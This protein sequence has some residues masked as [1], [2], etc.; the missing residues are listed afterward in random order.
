M[1]LRPARVWLKQPEPISCSPDIPTK[2]SLK[3]SSSKMRSPSQQ[4]TPAADTETSL[5]TLKK[6]MLLREMEMREVEHN[7][8]TAEH[9]A[10]LQQIETETREGSA[11][12]KWNIKI[13][14]LLYENE[15]AK[16]DPSTD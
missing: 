3:R 7:Q 15:L 10:R 12:R 9:E 2:N 4:P 14:A 6:Q 8:R 11:L 5:Q 16:K 13:A 1:Q